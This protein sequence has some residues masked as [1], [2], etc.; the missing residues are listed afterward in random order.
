MTVL[1]RVANDAADPLL[2]AVLKE[3][4]HGCRR[5][6]AAVVLFSLCINVLMLTVSLYMLHVYDSVLTSRSVDTL[7]AGPEFAQICRER[8]K[9]WTTGVSPISR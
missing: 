4:I 8:L 7:E 2:P 6:F 3:A 1:G 9:C 5:S